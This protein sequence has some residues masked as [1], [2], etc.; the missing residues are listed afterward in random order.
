MVETGWRSTST[1]APFDC[2]IVIV[3]ARLGVF[4]WP[5]VIA[6]GVFKPPSL[7]TLRWAGD[8]RT[9]V[10][11]VADRCPM[12]GVRLLNR[13]LFSWASVSKSSK[14]VILLTQEITIK[15][16]FTMTILLFE[17]LVIRITI[18]YLLWLV[19]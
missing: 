5:L 18:Y 7:L 8:A 3:P 1:S 10:P 15:I 11:A 9:Y 2:P 19:I 16:T 6:V 12:T 14:I 4:F 17:I 13:H